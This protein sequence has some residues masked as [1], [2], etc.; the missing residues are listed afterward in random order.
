MGG[1]QKV[2]VEIEFGVE[3]GDNMGRSVEGIANDWMAEGLH[4]DTDLMGTA[5]FDA[6]FDEGESTVRGLDAFEDPDM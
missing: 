3:I 1:M 6:D 2:A 4:V 5:G